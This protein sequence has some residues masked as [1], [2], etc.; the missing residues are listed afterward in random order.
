MCK[1]L[2]VTISSPIV[3]LLESIF[4]FS[5]SCMFLLSFADLKEII[6]CQNCVISGTNNVS[7]GDNGTII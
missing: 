3:L 4:R 2:L 1:L 7:A 5:N 6:F